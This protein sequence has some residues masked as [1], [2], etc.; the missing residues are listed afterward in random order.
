[1][2]AQAIKLSD[3]VYWV[4]AIDWGLK[5]FHGYETQGTTYNAY[6]ILADK[7]TLI[8]TVKAEFKDELLARIASVIEPDKIDYI[9]SNHAEK[10]HTGSLLEIIAITKPEKVF[11]SK[12]GV[13][14]LNEHF[15]MPMEITAVAEGETLD[16][17]N[18]TIKFIESKM[19]H[20]PDSMFSYLVEDGILFSNDAFGMHLASSERFDHELNACKL[21]YE[22]AKYYANIINP[23]SNLVGKLL[24]K[25]AQMNLNLKMITPDHGPVWQNNIAKILKLY[26][27]WCDPKPTLKGLIVYDTMWHSTE[28]MAFSIAE[29]MLAGGGKPKIMPLATF[30]ASDIVTEALDC[31]A[32]VVGCPTFNSGL[33]P[34]VAGFL[35]YVKG[36]KVRHVIGAAFG[37]Y[38]WSPG[39]VK[40]INETLT[41]MRIELASDGVQ[42]KYTPDNE[43]LEQCYNL[44]FEIAGKLHGL[45]KKD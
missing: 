14:A 16:L 23:F 15:V 31:G 8:D 42:A 45:A 40:Q 11:A 3:H 39:S 12:D 9:I 2:K 32:L 26:S 28:K 10:D 18:R 27:T 38:G 4:G 30:H 13:K 1:M 20:W 37:S 19:I 7:I 29:G 21:E 43:A 25:L 22:A 34:S 24:T 44:G 33:L 6:L 5:E 35:Q 41:S 36:L 17:G